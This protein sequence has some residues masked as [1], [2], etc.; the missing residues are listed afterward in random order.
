MSYVRLLLILRFVLIGS[1]LAC[2]EQSSDEL[3]AAARKAEAA[4]VSDSSLA[5]RASEQFAVFLQLFPQDE[6]CDDAL[7][8][9]AML[10]RQQGEMRVAIAHY[11]RL[12]RDHS[13][14]EFG[15][16]AQ[17]MIAFIYEEHLRELE[18]ARV[19]YNGVIERFPGSEL[20]IS[21]Q[22][23]LPHIGE[24]PE[25]WVPFQDGEDG[26]LMPHDQASVE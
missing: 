5:R 2:A 18:K 6:R 11:E 14:S 7:R 12:L 23:L 20:A 15:A 13:T 26:D 25:D 8:S 3:F 16:E 1:I 17:F 10:S 21:A 22:R 9:L 4:A 19:A 24:N